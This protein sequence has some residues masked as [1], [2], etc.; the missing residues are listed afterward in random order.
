M[1]ARIE[2]NELEYLIS[3]PKEDYSLEF[4]TNFLYRILNE[5]THTDSR[6]HGDIISRT[7][8]YDNPDRFDHLGDK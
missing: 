2:G 8:D 3:L 4:L 5:G 6:N 1:K 7:F